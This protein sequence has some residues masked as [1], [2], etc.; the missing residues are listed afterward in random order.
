MCGAVSGGGLWSW[1]GLCWANGVF[2]GPP[3]DYEHANKRRRVDD[4][5]GGGR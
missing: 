4:T 5:N 1:V 2:T 3:Q